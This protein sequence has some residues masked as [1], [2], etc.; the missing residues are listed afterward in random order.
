MLFK[1]SNT[2]DEVIRIE[3]IPKTNSVVEADESVQNPTMSMEESLRF[4]LAPTDL[5]YPFININQAS[6]EEPE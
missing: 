1:L 5:E 4:C 6:Y 2:G 3:I